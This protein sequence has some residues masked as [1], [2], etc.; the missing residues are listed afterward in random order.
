MKGV[1][2]RENVSAK[3]STALVNYIN[4]QPYVKSL[5]YVSKE[6]ARQ[7]YLEDGNK[8]WV[9]VL[10]NNPCRPAFNFKVKGEYAVTDSITKNLQADLVQNISRQR[11]AIPYAIAGSSLNKHD[12]Q[13]L[14]LFCWCLA[15]G[16]FNFSNYF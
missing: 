5:E 7:K 12:T 15:S 8:D 2:C 16:H 6:T 9:G 13:N 1:L 4:S 14:V 10:Q 3:D 11:C